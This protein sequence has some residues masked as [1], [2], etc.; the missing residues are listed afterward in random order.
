MDA[1]ATMMVVPAWVPIWRRPTVVRLI[2][3]VVLLVGLV[4]MHHLIATQCH[5]VTSMSAVETASP[6]GHHSPSYI[7]DGS[8]SQVVSVAESAASGPG[9]AI[10]VTIALCLAILF[11]LVQGFRR[12]THLQPLRELGLRHPPPRWLSHRLSLEPSLHML[13]RSRT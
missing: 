10:P 12:S 8:P 13:S 1:Q 2:G 3:I 11:T 6:L 4:G 5:H 7:P 9:G